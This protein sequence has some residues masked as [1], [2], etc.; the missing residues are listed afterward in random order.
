MPQEGSMSSS[1]YKFF[2]WITFFALTLTACNVPFLNADETPTATPTSADPAP[3]TTKEATPTP[4]PE[5]ALN[6]CLGQEPNTLYLYDE[7]NPAAQ[8]VLQAIYDGP[9]DQYNYAYEPVILQKLPSLQ[10]GTAKFI[11]TPVQEGDWVV[12]TD[13]EKIELAQGSRVYPA[14]CADPSCAITYK[15]DMNL[16]MEQ[17]V[18]N[19]SLL[20]DL[21]WADGAELTADDS[22]YAYDLAIAS[23]S[24][25]YAYLL[26]R[27]ESYEAVDYLTVTWRGIP[28][29][30]DNS[31]QDNFWQPLPYHV[32][33]SFSASELV[34]ADVAARY[35]LGWG[36]YVIDIWN[37]GESIRLIKNPLYH[38]A[39]EGLPH[40]D[41]INFLFTPNPND[42]IAALLDGQCDLLD[43]SISLDHQVPLLQSLAANKQIQLYNTETLS[44]E[45]LHF[46]I[47]PA[48]YDDG[49]N[50][51]NERPPILSNTGTRQ[52][53]ALCLD[54]QGVVDR[55][56][57]GLTTVPDS[58][59]PNAHPLYSPQLELYPYNPTEGAQRLQNIGWKDLDNDPTTP[60][61]ALNIIG[62]PNGTKL[63][64]TYLTTTSMQ[65]RQT[66]EILAA[67]LRECGIGVTV[68]YLSP[69]DLYA[70][71]PAGPLFGRQFDLAQFAMGSESLRPRCDWFSTNA[72]PN[73]KNDWQGANISGYSSSDY[74]EAC[75]T[76]AF[77]LPNSNLYQSSYQKTLAIYAKDLPA[78]PIYPYLSFAAARPDLSGFIM[79]ASAQNPLWSIEN[80]DIAFTSP[81]SKSALGTEAPPSTTPTPDS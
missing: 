29:Y 80:W 15:P 28:G 58:Y 20:P 40:F 47:N 24:P 46:G 67:S 70:P 36:P 59:I 78:V 53:I 44:L 64:L 56:L 2:V 69:E 60:R 43:P 32:W 41:V 42:A 7:P 71:G 55:V 37:P 73:A 11:N 10:D 18:V 79:D 3:A 81:A 30:R 68:E 17:M 33:S 75:Q 9:I 65:R 50:L 12:N 13:G 22:V 16:Q 49:I 35:P 51:G 54:R 34:D 48:A 5:R 8:S 38:R 4:G 25:S 76:A 1:A 19:F 31:Y 52:A 45:S 21:L 57:H 6:I 23:K 66:S 14:G 62:I 72:I 63:N 26:E 77:S 74:D 27:T 39:D 61:T